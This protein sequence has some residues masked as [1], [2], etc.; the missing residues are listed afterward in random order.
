M[1]NKEIRISDKLV[2]NPWQKN[3]EYWVRYIKNHWR[4]DS[5]FNSRVE[6]S[7]FPIFRRIRF[8]YGIKHLN[9]LF[10]HK[11]YEN[12]DIEIIKEDIDQF[13]IK[14]SKLQSFI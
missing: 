11:I 14:I 8:Y 3:G 1:I 5:Y 7:P 2:F 12:P 13:L 10:N 4:T 6:I 9:N